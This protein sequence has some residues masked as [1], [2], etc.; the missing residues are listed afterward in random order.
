MGSD[1]RTLLFTTI[2]AL[3]VIL[4]GCTQQPDEQDYLVQ[5]GD[6][7]IT[8]EQFKRRVDAASEEAFP[9]EQAVAPSILQDLRVRVLNQITEELMISSHATTIGVAVSDE[10]LARMVDTI[11]SDYPDNTFEETLLE[12]AVSYESWK[13]KLAMRMLVDKVVKQEIVDT[14]EITSADVA[15][16]IQ[17][18]YPDG[19]PSDEDADT[20][21]QKI[22]RHLRHQKAEQ[23]YPQ[24]LE[25][26][27]KGYPV[28][29]NQS[30][31]NQ[32]AQ[33]DK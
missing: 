3:V 17:T 23:L 18:H 6:R 31:W 25:S 20:V 11:K 13:Q 19:P 2:L 27:R 21:H 4:L 12:N 1:F 24:W 33:A 26:L 15:A 5:V 14:V 30:R 29:I 16:Y 8:V 22:V 28:E 7:S 10:E 9:G 32:L